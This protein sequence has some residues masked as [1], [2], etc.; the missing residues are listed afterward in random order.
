MR[1]G[2]G[3][4]VVFNFHF[5]AISRNNAV[6]AHLAT[7]FAIEW[8][9]VRDDLHLVAGLRFGNLFASL[10]MALNGSGILQTVIPGE[11]AVAPFPVSSQDACV[12]SLHTFP[13]LPSHLPLATH[14][15]IKPA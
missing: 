5:A 6:V 12:F 14:F 8:R 10:M 15:F 4:S 9:P 13:G 1:L 3:R 11:I 7:G 2:N